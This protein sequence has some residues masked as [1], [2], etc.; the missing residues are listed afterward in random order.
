MTAGFLQLTI[1]GQ[2]DVYLTGNPQISFFKSVYKRYSKFSIQLLNQDINGT[3]HFNS[4]INCI[5]NKSGDLLKNIYLEITLP[6]LIKPDSLSWFGYVNNIGCS[7]IDRILLRINDQTIETIYGDWIDI[8]NNINNINIDKITKQ[9]N[10]DYMIRNI[11]SIDLEKRSFYVPIPFF[12]SK[13]SSVALPVIALSQSDISIDISFKKLEE[14]IKVSDNVFINEVQVKPDSK[15]ECNLWAEYIY[16][17]EPEKKY[18]STKKLEYLIE[19][20]QFNGNEVLN[21]NDIKKNIYLDFRHPVKELIWT[22]S[23]DNSNLDTF[24]NIDHNNITKYTTRYSDYKDTFDK[25]SIK[26]N[27]LLL[28]NSFKAEY[29]R[30]I[31]SYYYHNNSRNKYIYSY[32]FSLNPT[33]N[34]PSGHLNFSELT[35]EL[36]IFDFIDSSIPTAGKATNGIIKIYAINYNILQIN[37]GQGSLQ[38]Y[39][40]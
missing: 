27:S 24:L 36:F 30:K 35:D 26:L 4:N 19:Q 14:V 38:Y 15:F 9:Y 23:V 39:I 17:D 25:L 18:F 31:Q 29:Y 28:L 12:F 2:Q 10:S 16:L 5:L 1:N 3:P 21:K 22:I 40:N 11:N 32:S 13:S 8:Y 20:T 6:D 7:I 33:Q 37:S 34:Q